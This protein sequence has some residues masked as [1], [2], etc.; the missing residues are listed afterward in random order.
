MACRA[1]GLMGK[2]DHVGE[3]QVMGNGV[4][5]T[6]AAGQEGVLESE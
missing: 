3:G 2:W 4:N 5:I 6:V 1:T